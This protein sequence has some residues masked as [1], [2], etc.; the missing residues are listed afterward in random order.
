[1][2]WDLEGDF[3]GVTDGEREKNGYNTYVSL[4]KV[5]V[6]LT[7]PSYLNLSFSIRTSSAS[8]SPNASLSRSDSWPTIQNGQRGVS[9]LYC[10]HKGIMITMI[11]CDPTA[12]DWGPESSQA[13]IPEKDV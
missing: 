2:R 6:L 13:Q 1:M 7:M 3:G 12:P 5:V 10:T 4:W 9:I 8:T 11:I